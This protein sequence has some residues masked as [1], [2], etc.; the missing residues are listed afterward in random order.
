[1]SSKNVETIRAADEAWNRRD[2][3]GAVRA[4]AENVTF[5]DSAQNRTLRGRNEYRQWLENW[6]KSF[7][8]GRI[9][10]PRYHDAGDTVIVE[11]TGEGTNDGPFL[12]YAPTRKRVSIP[13]CEIWRFDNQGR[14]ISGAG[15]YDV[16]TLLTQLGH[17]KPLAVAA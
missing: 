5:T 15:Y 14:V 11:F 12:T 10:N 7:S 6:A 4:F 8:D 17:A 16:Y 2:F 3:E 9:T 1:M 13:F